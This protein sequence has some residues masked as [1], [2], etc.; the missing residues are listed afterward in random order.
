MGIVPVL[1]NFC[2]R[3]PPYPII[4]GISMRSIFIIKKLDNFRGGIVKS[5]SPADLERAEDFY[6]VATK[7]DAMSLNRYKV[8]A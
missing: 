3:N 6:V 5:T 4:Y 8:M 1:L 2:T 7:A